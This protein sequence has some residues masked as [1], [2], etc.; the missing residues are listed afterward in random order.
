MKQIAEVGIHRKIF[1]DGYRVSAVGPKVKATENAG[2]YLEGENYHFSYLTSE[3]NIVFSSIVCVCVCVG[4][5]DVV[6]NK[7]NSNFVFM[8]IK[9][10][11][12]T[13]KKAFTDVDIKISLQTVI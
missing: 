5:T 7:R 4:G 12:D 6:E 13:N 1:S 9:R 8:F 10:F 2:I 3:C 11:I